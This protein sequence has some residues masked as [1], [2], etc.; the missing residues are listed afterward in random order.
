[1]I[2]P[3]DRL[4]DAL[5]DRYAFERELGSGGMATVWLAQD[6]KLQ[7]NVALKVLRP[8]L[9]A[10]MGVERFLAE[11]R[12]TANLSHPHILPLY[13]S[14]EADGLLYY[15]MPHV[16]GETLKQRLGR[17]R[18]I[19]IDEALQIA[20][21]IA[22]ALCHAH[23]H[24]IIHRDIKPANILFQD[25]EPLVADFGIALAVSVAGKGRLTESG[26]SLGTPHYMSPEQAT[27]ET[28]LTAATDI[29]SLGAVLYE[30]LSGEPPHRGA[31]VQS[32][33]AR[34][35]T[36]DPTH[37][38]VLRSSI[39]PAVDAAV[40]KALAKRPIDRFATAEEFRQHLQRLQHASAKSPPEAPLPRHDLVEKQFTLTAEVC[41]QIDRAELDPLMI[42]DHVAYLDNEASSD[43][44]VV[45]IHGFGGDQEVFREILAQSPYRGMAVTLYGFEPTRRRRPSLSLQSHCAILRSFLDYVVGSCTPAVSILA[46]FSAGADLGFRLITDTP[47]E[48]VIPLDGYL[49]VGCNVNLET[50]FVSR[51]LAAQ[52]SERASEILPELRTT[53]TKA[54]D[55][56]EWLNIHEYLVRILRKFQSDLHVLRRHGQDIITPF[57]EG[58]DAFS[59]WFREASGRVRVLRCVFADTP[60]ESRPVRRL[61]VANL[62]SGVLGERYHEDAIRIE[63]G[64]DHFDLLSPDVLNR[65]LGEI[66]EAL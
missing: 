47:S 33:I 58:E 27:G 60:L 23:R 51:V 52:A 31:S 64:L 14:G 12:I 16:E 24:G 65:Y 19:A 53:G 40:M 55:L 8:D 56:A 61:L 32:I 28:A 26:I 43:V 3:V 11:I 4:K 36:E 50:C 18:Q 1:M 54:A 57:L 63:R 34:L 17:E 2:E 13:D 39:P 5:R 22:D 25:G 48:R 59:S 46:G 66:I 38:R 6:L 37:P 20:A 29:Y 15:A 62:D 30:M 49:S 7:R 44:L 9:A 10:V 21:R 45:Y 41:R 35:L 42:G